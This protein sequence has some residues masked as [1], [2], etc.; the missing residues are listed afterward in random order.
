MKFHA[1]GRRFIVRM[2]I[3]LLTIGNLAAQAETK[4]IGTD[5]F[6]AS[7]FVVDHQEEVYFWTPECFGCDTTSILYYALQLDQNIVSTSGYVVECL[8]DTCFYDHNFQPIDRPDFW[9]REGIKIELIEDSYEEGY[10]VVDDFEPSVMHGFEVKGDCQVEC[11]GK[12]WP[13]KRESLGDIA[14]G[15]K[16]TPEE[17]LKIWLK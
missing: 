12:M 2:I 16:V 4:V 9:M 15:S 5:T 13:V 11:M 3:F 8:N 14:P 17:L 1:Q 6:H 7:D 10:E